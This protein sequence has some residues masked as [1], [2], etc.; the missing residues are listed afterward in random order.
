MSKQDYVQTISAAFGQG[1]KDSSGNVDFKKDLPVGED[2][3]HLG[4]MSVSGFGQT[5]AEKAGLRSAVLQFA[6]TGYDDG[7]N[8][9][10]KA[11]PKVPTSAIPAWVRGQVTTIEE[12]IRQDLT[13]IYNA[14][15]AAGA[16]AGPDS[17]Q[18]G[19]SWVWWVLGGS[20]AVLGIGAL[21]LSDRKHPGLALANPG[22]KYRYKLAL[23]DSGD[24]WTDTYGKNEDWPE[25]VAKA[26]K[27]VA[28][29]RFNKAILFDKDAGTQE[30]FSHEAVKRNPSFGDLD[31]IK[32]LFRDKNLQLWG[33]PY[34]MRPNTNQQP[35]DIKRAHDE[36]VWPIP[37]SYGP[38]QV[39]ISDWVWLGSPGWW[40]DMSKERQAQVKEFLAAHQDLVPQNWN[41]WSEI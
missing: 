7:A 25:M 36:Y 22:R 35:A 38:K 34:R 19:S 29:S 21:V 24:I 4:F 11:V 9:K 14:A 31:K 17:V 26:K 8:K 28:K 37:G 13:G 12:I 20:A 40:G 18:S 30:H 1:V 27:W 2:A 15:Y 23:I 32:V 33:I 39:S 10:P 5:D 41:E 6:G 16:S 3:Y